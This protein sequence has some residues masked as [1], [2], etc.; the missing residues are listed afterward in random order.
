MKETEFKLKENQLKMKK[1][2]ELRM[3]NL[4][5]EEL[6]IKEKELDLKILFK[7]TTGMTDTQLQECEISCNLIREKHR[8]M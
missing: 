6:K 7:D 3:K 5:E 8:I 2:F 1:K 4:K